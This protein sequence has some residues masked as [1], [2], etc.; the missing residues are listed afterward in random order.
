MFKKYPTIFDQ[1][2]KLFG[3]Y[4]ETGNYNTNDNNEKN[5]IKD[6]EK[7]TYWSL[8][9]IIFLAICVIVLGIILYKVIPLIKR[10]KKANELDEDFDYEPHDNKKESDKEYNLYNE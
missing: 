1:D 4:L 3:F 10:K 5:N 9:I 7:K 6:N 2:N 8:I